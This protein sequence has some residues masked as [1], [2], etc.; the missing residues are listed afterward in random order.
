LELPTIEKLHKAYK[1]KG[2]VVLGVDKEEA[3]VVRAFNKKNDAVTF[4]TL[5]D[6]AGGVTGHYGV[7]A[8]PTTLLLDRKGRIVSRIEGT[9]EDQ[10]LQDL[11]FRRLLRKAGLR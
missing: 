4:P 5:E 1:D 11:Q 9:E 3:G 7:N 2:L 6:K 8:F 10:A